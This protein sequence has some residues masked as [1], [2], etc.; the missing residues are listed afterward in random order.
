MIDI[1]KNTLA[2][3]WMLVKEI[4]WKKEKFYTWLLHE[5]GVDRLHDMTDRNINQ[6]INRL[7]IM[8]PRP[9]APRISTYQLDLIYYY[10]KRLVRDQRNLENY[11]AAVVK[12]ITGLDG[13]QF[14]EPK[15]AIKVIEALKAADRRIHGKDPGFHERRPA[16]KVEKAQPDQGRPTAGVQDLAGVSPRAEG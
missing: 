14:L 16:G 2:K 1:P 13:I 7:A 5:Y 10:A 6:M 4:G 12:G 8:K 9:V 15:T 3:I 11:V